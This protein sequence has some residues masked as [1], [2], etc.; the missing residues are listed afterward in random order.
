MSTTITPYSF[1]LPADPVE[2]L[3]LISSVVQTGDDSLGRAA[4]VDSMR[5]RIDRLLKASNPAERLAELA[6]HA[7]L[8]SDMA[9]RYS[10]RA[11]EA[12]ERGPKAVETWQRLALQCQAAHT[13]TIIAIEG[14]KAQAR[15]SARVSLAEDARDDDDDARDV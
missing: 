1:R 15:G 13:R 10:V 7:C 6:A 9:A 3:A 5:Q 11:L 2:G 12:G 8:L 14:L 4:A